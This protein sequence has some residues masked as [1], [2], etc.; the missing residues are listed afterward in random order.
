MLTSAERSRL[1][2]ASIKCTASFS[3][4]S[5]LAQ[6]SAMAARHSAAVLSSKG[7]K[8]RFGKKE[9][10]APTRSTTSSMTCEVN[11]WKREKV[12]KKKGRGREG[13]LVF[14]KKRGRRNMNGN[15]K[16]EQK[17]RQRGMTRFLKK[18]TGRRKK[19]TDKHLLKQ[20]VADVSVR[21]TNV[22]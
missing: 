14:E 16:K 17:E 8:S 10:R 18:K 6:N 12:S 1:K 19:K 7:S 9:M 22:D 11:Q 20:E 2:E 4:A 15:G 3:M 13:C 5:T 21:R